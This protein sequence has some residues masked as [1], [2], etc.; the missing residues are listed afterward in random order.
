MTCYCVFK[1]K[2]DAE[3]FASFLK[4][5]GFLVTMDKADGIWSLFVSRV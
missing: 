2:R 4:S 5:N 3:S 1:S